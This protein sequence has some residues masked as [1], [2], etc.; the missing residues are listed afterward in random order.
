MR[1]LLD[2][3]LPVSLIPRLERLGHEAEH[4][5]RLEMGDAADSLIWAEAQRR[6]AVVVSKDSDFLVLAATSGRL[7]R[8]RVGNRPNQELFAIVERGW[9]EVVAQLERG[10]RVVEL[11]G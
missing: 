1:F 4:V 8:L 2:Q 6:N 5:K 11:R 10:E 9:P 7:V 3:H